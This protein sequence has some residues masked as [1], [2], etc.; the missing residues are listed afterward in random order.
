MAEKAPTPAAFPARLRPPMSLSR[1]SLFLFPALLGLPLHAEDLR[2]V[3]IRTPAGQMKYDLSVITAAPGSQL[4]LVFEN[5][6]EM[7]H[8]FVLCRPLP[9]KADKGL[10]LAQLAWQLGAVGM[11][12]AWIPDSPRVLA[13]TGMVAPHQQESLVIKVPDQ[14]GSYPYVCTFP[15]H[16]MAMNGELRVVQQGPRFTALD[17]QLF[18]GDWQALPDFAA[19]TP[20][21]RG[22]IP[23]RLLTIELEGLTQHFALRYD[24]TLEVPADGEYTFFLASDDGSALSIDG[25]SLIKHDGIHPA[26]EV[27]SQKVALKAGT[28]PVRL[29]YFESTGEEQ[30]YLAW[31]G[32]SFS[33]TPLSRWVHPSRVPGAQDKAPQDDFTG[34]PLAPANGEAIIYRNFIT[35]TSPRGI[36]VGYPNGVNLC[37]DADQM[38]PSLFWQGAFMDAKRHWTGRGEGAQPP[39]GYNVLHIAPPG[40]AL[41]FLPDPAAPW[42]PKTARAAALHFKG[43]HLDAKRFPTF[44]YQI[45]PVAVEESYQPEGTAAQ[46]NLHFTRTLRC[47]APAGTPTLHL[48]AAAGS[49]RPDPTGWAGPGFH[50]AAP[51]AFLRGEEL[52]LPL[53]FPQGSAT[54]TLTYHWT[55]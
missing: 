12:K 42:P 30:L 5:L 27:R 54:A 18:L 41:A 49:L 10:E 50:V 15:G 4:K 44:R 40:P 8:N 14:P 24:A 35:E 7:P 38:A 52:L 55:P 11:E 17:Y 26:S 32:P 3:T 37:F 22:P 31:S 43:Y 51:S 25:Q 39:L 36:A 45:G 2:T 23:D 53:A 6:D 29:D 21:R 48:R 16:A 46:N 13:H 28:H 34:I 47:Q 9:D 20:H 33:E 19:L 1:L